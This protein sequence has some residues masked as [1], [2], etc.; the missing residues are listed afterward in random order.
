LYFDGIEK[1]SKYVPTEQQFQNLKD[2]LTLI[3]WRVIDVGGQRSE[4]RKWADQFDG[5]DAI[6]WVVNLS[7]YSTRLF[8]DNSMNRMQEELAALSDFLGPK[9]RWCIGKQIILLLNKFDLFEKN[10]ESFPFEQYV[11][12]FKPTG[13][14]DNHD[15]Y[16]QEA[17]QFAKEKFLA[18]LEHHKDVLVMRCIATDF[19]TMSDIYNSTRNIILKNSSGR[20]EQAFKEQES[21]YLEQKKAQ[22]NKGNILQLSKARYIRKVVPQDDDHFKFHAQ[23]TITMTTGWTVGGQM[24]TQPLCRLISPVMVLVAD[25]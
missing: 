6:I 19:D 21:I 1:H 2:S 8:E 24:A 4:R 16:V 20:L 22:K 10:L 9:Q 11:P 17:F 5:V 12:D 13:A 18:C 25:Q 3:K 15:A 7:G 23:A 14:T